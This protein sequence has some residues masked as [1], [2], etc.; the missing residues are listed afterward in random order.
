MND[1]KITYEELTIKSV[2]CA[3]CS[4]NEVAILIIVHM[5]IVSMLRNT[6]LFHCATLVFGE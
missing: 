4:Q 2:L 3:C 1:T 5:L 6:S